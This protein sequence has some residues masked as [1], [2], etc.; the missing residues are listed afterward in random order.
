MSSFFVR[1]LHFANGLVAEY[2]SIYESHHFL[3]YQ[4]TDNRLY[5]YI[6]SLILQILCKCSLNFP[7]PIFLIF[8]HLTPLCHSNLVYSQIHKRQSWIFQLFLHL[9]MCNLLFNRNIS[10]HGSDPSYKQHVL[11]RSCLTEPDP[12][13]AKSF[14]I[15]VCT[16][17]CFHLDNPTPISAIY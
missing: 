4:Y 3:S 12:S 10:K 8:K 1:C 15:L 6:N 5:L 17:F 9:C 2:H 7:K 16:C 11:T 13:V 14:F